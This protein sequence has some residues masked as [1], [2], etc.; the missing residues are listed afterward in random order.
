MPHIPDSHAAHDPLLVAAFAAGDASGAELE[1][2]AA[3]VAG[4]AGCA[5]LHRDLR[6]IAAALPTLPAPAR[7]RDFRLTADQAAALRPGGWRRLLAP[8]AG[9]RFAF[10]GPLG[11]G[12][13]TL[14]LAGILVAG[15]AGLPVSAPTSGAATGGAGA[16][17]ERGA[18][19]G[20]E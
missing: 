12:L 18:G 15:G 20:S 5:E 13:A 14:G 8:L 6:A 17:V 19:G 4:C 10:A 1:R 3:L 9:P 2:A 11:A 16:A 7:P